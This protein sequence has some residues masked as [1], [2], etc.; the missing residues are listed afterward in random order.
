MLLALFELVARANV[1][2]LGDQSHSD[3]AEGQ[4]CQGNQSGSPPDFSRQ[5]LSFSTYVCMFWT[6]K[7]W[8]YSVST[9][10]VWFMSWIVFDHCRSDFRPGRQASNI[11]VGNIHRV[12]C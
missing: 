6:L 3:L 5:T 4:Y 12:K 11:S 7:Y 9:A 8:Q 2:Q 1:P 10:H